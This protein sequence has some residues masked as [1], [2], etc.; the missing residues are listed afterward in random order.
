MSR[1]FPHFDLHV[2]IGL[3]SPSKEDAFEDCNLLVKDAAFPTS[4]SL[5]PYYIATLSKG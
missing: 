3:C 5:V 1:I 4:R 2:T